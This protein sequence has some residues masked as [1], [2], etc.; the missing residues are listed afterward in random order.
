MKKETMIWGIA[1]VLVVVAVFVTK[2]N[3]LNISSQNQPGLTS[4]IQLNTNSLISSEDNSAWIEPKFR[5]SATD[6]SLSDL[7][8]NRVSSKGLQ[9]KN[10][11]INFW[12]TWCPWCVKELP[13]IE[14]V[15]Q[16]YKDKSLVIL[17]ID[18]GEDKETVNKFIQQ[19]N[20]HFNVLLDSVQTVAQRYNISSI[21]VSI[22][23]DKNGKIAQRITGAMKEDQIIADIDKLMNEK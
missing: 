7:N 2:N 15:Y 11:Y 20:Y 4:Q 17:A 6:F 22:F 21:P 5:Q 19:N 9:G 10:I 1:I 23:I 8:G 16:K 18:L 3:E 12:A 13:D 14:K